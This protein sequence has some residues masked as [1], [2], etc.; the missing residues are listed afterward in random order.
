MIERLATADTFP[1]W[2][3]GTQAGTK[4]YR[5]LGSGTA[6]LSLKDER[7]IVYRFT[8]VLPN[9]INEAISMIDEMPA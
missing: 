4:F 5:I 7:E 2:L 8:E 9:T 1:H 6:Y 3:D